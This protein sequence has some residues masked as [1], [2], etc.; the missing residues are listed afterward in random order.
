MDDD[1]KPP[2]EEEIKLIEAR[3]AR[4]DQISKLMSGYLLK[5]Y[6]MLGSECS[7]CGTILL[8]DRS[9]VKH[10]VACEELEC[11]TEKDD[12]AMRPPGAPSQIVKDEPRVIN[13]NQ[14]I[15]AAC[16]PRVVQSS[17]RVAAHSLRA[18]GPTIDSDQ[19]RVGAGDDGVGAEYLSMSSIDVH[20]WPANSVDLAGARSDHVASNKTNHGKTGQHSMPSGSACSDPAVM[21]P[22][23]IQKDLSSSNDITSCISVLQTKICWASQILEQNNNVESST[24]LCKLIKAAAE[25]IVAVRKASL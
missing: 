5:G 14:T 25:A 9:S 3:R 21:Q 20:C 15:S 8:Q 24:E 13:S 17:P 12:P 6:R 7:T 10:C 4:S 11:D 1:W 23:C 19:Q 22:V 16:S 18:K 2:T